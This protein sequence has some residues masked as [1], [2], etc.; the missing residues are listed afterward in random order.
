MSS[1]SDPAGRA[2]RAARPL[3]CLILLAAVAAGLG[4]CAGEGA[5][6]P[7]DRLLAAGN[8]RN[9][10]VAATRPVAGRPGFRYWH[11]DATGAWY[12]PGDA[13]GSPHAGA[14]YRERWLVLLETGRYGLF[15]PTGE[16]PAE[17]RPA[18]APSWAPPFA[19]AAEG[20]RVDA[21][22]WDAAGDPLHARFDGSAWRVDRVGAVLQKDEV[23]AP[24]AAYYAGRVYLVWREPYEPLPGGGPT[25]RLRFR[26]REDGGEAWQG[27]PSRLVVGDGPYLAATD[28]RMACLYRQ[29]GGEAAPGPW[30]L[31][32][33]ETAD[34][35]FHEVGPLKGD[36][37]AGPLALARWRDGFVLA[38]RADGRPAVAA[39]DIETAEAGVFEPVPAAAADA[40]AEPL[41]LS[42]LT[43]A[44]FMGFALLL[45]WHG[46][47]ARER[48]G[49]MVQAPVAEGLEQAP[50]VRRAAALVIDMVLVSLAMVPALMVT[51]PDV[52]AR[53]ADWRGE[54]SWETV[55]VHLVG[56]GILIVYTTVAEGLVGRTVGK[57]LLRMEVRTV[58]GRPIGWGRAVGRNVMRFVDEF[59]GF[60][61]IGMLSI[62]IGP[63]RQ[64]VGDRLAH[65]VVVMRPRGGTEP[66]ET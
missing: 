8:A 10:Y 54:R 41:W 14:A 9:L 61:L 38:G 30:A 7:A 37:P 25:F 3:A 56:T 58:T 46:R 23:L 27:G 6:P 12:R 65:T 19:V 59:P 40:E 28:D 47:A 50:L 13:V 20:L 31:A 52:V 32:V 55:V 62:L 45:V 11:R 34:E 44:A 18:P 24:A 35:D 51:A 29:P 17:V 53:L 36:L 26:Y 39:L 21:F 66:R 64:G 5:P 48:A 1:S 4:G 22:G 15:G 49:R 42:V 57:A 43:M 63:L 33:Y 16:A 2:A 60:Y